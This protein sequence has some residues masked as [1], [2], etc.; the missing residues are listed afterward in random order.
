M[1]QRVSGRPAHPWGLAF[2]DYVA[3]HIPEETTTYG[4]P[5]HLPE[6]V[7]TGVL[8]QIVMNKSGGLI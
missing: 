1:G 6:R 2:V 8:Y 3:G 7:N 5:S 4:Q